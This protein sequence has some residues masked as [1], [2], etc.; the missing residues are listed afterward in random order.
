MEEENDTKVDDYTIYDVIDRSLYSD[1]K[2]EHYISNPIIG[3]KVF[4][5]H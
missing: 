5:I 3:K 1:R 4:G 2:F